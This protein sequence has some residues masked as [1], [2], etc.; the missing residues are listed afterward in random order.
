V[1]KD[2][3]LKE[4]V[5]GGVDAMTKKWFDGGMKESYDEMANKVAN[6]ISILATS[7]LI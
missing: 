1:L 3:Y 2:D 7:D 6:Y 4:F 5:A